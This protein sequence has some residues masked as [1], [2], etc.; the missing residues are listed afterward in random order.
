MKISVLGAGRIGSVLDRLLVGAGHDVAVAS[1]RGP[2]ALGD[3]VAELGPRATAMDTEEAARAADVV[4]LMVPH[5]RVEGLVE[6]GALAGRV[7]IDATNAFPPRGGDGPTSTEQVAALY[8]GATVVKSLN[9]MNYVALA[10]TAGRAGDRRM[11][12]YVAGDDP[13]AKTLVA[14]IVGGLGFAVLDTGT[15]HAGGG[16]QEPGGP[17][18]NILFTRSEA[19]RALQQAGFRA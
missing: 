18:F 16:L 2:A 15:L 12:H 19:E 6:P 11:A 4:V 14:D 3:L 1:R 8:P 17:L 5:N 10:E 9:T 7:L 13:A